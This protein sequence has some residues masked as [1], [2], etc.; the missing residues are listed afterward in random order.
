M[1]LLC[2][3]HGHC[4]DGLASAV[5]F[6][7]W[8]KRR[9]DCQLSYRA[10]GYGPKQGRPESP[11]DADEVAVL[12]YRYAPLENLR[13][14]F[15]HHRTAFSELGSKEHFDKKRDEAPRYFVYNAETTSCTRLLAEHLAEEP[16]FELTGLESLVRWADIVDAARF[17]SAEAAS[18]VSSPVLRL[19]SVVEQ[20]GDDAFLTH[21]VPLIEK[22]GLEAFTE[23]PMVE[24][25]YASIAPHHAQYRDLVRTRGRLRDHIA[26]VDLTDDAI[27]AV[28]KFAV[29]AEFPTALYSVVLAK[30]SSAVR[31]SI[32]YN[33]WSG[34]ERKH[35]LGALCA[36]YG[37]GGH[38]V[39]G[40]ISLSVSELERAKQI[41]LELLERLAL[42]AADS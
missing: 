16:E 18:D 11:S 15:D 21:A 7:R 37:G 27:K 8:L 40:G 14:Y 34:L 30:L 9:P 1:R 35:D 42:G 17:P 26:D 10:C 31:I 32:G 29:Y 5:V 28:T 25:R 22:A 2:A 36:S 4:F 39:V 13:Y 6:T 24:A 3:T 12:D 19:V 20:F 41:R 38:P 33:P 23:S